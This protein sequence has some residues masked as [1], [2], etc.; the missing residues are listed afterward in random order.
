MGRRAR[1]STL[2]NL[3]GANQY[4]N[5]TNRIKVRFIRL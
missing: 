2:R 3:A 4:L 5:N 1:F